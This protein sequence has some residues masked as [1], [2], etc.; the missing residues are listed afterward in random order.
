MGKYFS[1]TFYEKQTQ[2]GEIWLRTP[3]NRIVSAADGLK[4]VFSKYKYAT[5]SLPLADNSNRSFY[6]DINEGVYFTRFDVIQ[7]VVFVET[8]RGTIFDQIV[9]ENNEIYPKTQDNNF[10]TSLSSNRL[11]FPDYWFDENNRKIFIATYR[12]ENFQPN[13]KNFKLGYIIEEFDMK[14]SVLDVINYFTVDFNFDTKVAYKET[15]I[16]E[17]LKITYNKETKMFNL[18]HICRGPKKE[19]GLISINLLRDQDLSVKNVNAFFSFSKTTDVVFEKII[20]K[21]TTI[22]SDNQ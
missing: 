20:Q 11:R 1:L 2:P 21:K 18:S 5:A 14:R 15:P 22:D 12:N 4:N 3:D 13:T 10:T 7:D 16:A 19:F 9:V 8:P 6:Q 17:P